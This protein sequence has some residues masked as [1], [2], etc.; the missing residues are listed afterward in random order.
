MKDEKPKD[1][2]TEKAKPSKKEA[3]NKSKKLL[4][5]HLISVKTIKKKEKPKNNLT[6]KTPTEQKSP[7]NTQSH[8]V[9]NIQTRKPIL[10]ATSTKH[11]GGSIISIKSQNSAY[12]NNTA[13]A[14]LE[15]RS[16][17][18]IEDYKRL[19]L[20]HTSAASSRKFNNVS[21]E[22]YVS[23]KEYGKMLR[24][25]LNQDKDRTRGV[26]SAAAITEA[27]AAK[28]FCKQYRQTLKSLNLSNPILSLN[29]I[30]NCKLHPVG[31]ILISQKFVKWSARSGEESLEQK[32]WELLHED[33]HKGVK[34]ERLMIFL[35]AIMNVQIIQQEVDNA[36]GVLDK[37]LL[38]SKKQVAKIHKDFYDYYSNKNLSTE[39]TKGNSYITGEEYKLK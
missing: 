20:T 23:P 8:T 1:S 37:E 18:T 38:L 2:I 17:N 15:H 28:R 26:V 10:N 21:A 5:K 31:H 33:K 27:L 12:S 32:L 39:R 3:K 24:T 14:T 7:N 16:H 22:E 19:I 4:I 9:I 13:G 36:Y 6:S 30:S 11:K 34:S 35:A 29:D 25:S